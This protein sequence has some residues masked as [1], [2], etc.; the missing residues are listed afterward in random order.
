MIV[1]KASAALDIGVVLRLASS[2]S[3]KGLFAGSGEMSAPILSPEAPRSFEGPKRTWTRDEL[4]GRA[5]GSGE[6]GKLRRE[7]TGVGCGVYRVEYTSFAKTSSETRCRLNWIEPSQ[8][9]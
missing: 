3:I 7:V 4:H 6:D 8:R 2:A 9:H 1:N 5:S